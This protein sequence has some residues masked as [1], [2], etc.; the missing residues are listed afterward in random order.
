M[1]G[2]RLFRNIR[3]SGLGWPIDEHRPGRP[4]HYGV[5]DI[6][7]QQAGESGA[8]VRR[9]RDRRRIEPFGLR[10]DCVGNV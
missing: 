8:N 1:A 4:V 3:R 7:V 10:H 6:S 2:A 9:H 5:R